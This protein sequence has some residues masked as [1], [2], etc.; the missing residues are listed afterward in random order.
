M[1]LIQSDSDWSIAGLL[2]QN[3]LAEVAGSHRSSK[4]GNRRKYRTNLRI[5]AGLG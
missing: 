2:H 4:K 5:V 3:E 1:V